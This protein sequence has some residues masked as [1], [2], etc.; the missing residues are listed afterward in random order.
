[1]IAQFRPRKK[2]FALAGAL[3]LAGTLG[4]CA[5]GIE[6]NGKVFDLLGVSANSQRKG[7][8]KLVERAPLVVPPS[9]QLPVPGARSQA[10][11]PRDLAWPVDSDQQKLASVEAKKQKIR[12]LCADRSW[13]E[14]TNQEE[15]DRLTKN[16]TECSSLLGDLIKGATGEEDTSQ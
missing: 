4:G 9:N 5:D 14:R 3:L 11:A 15:F 13:Q 10:A 1:M 8:A 2:L 7:E 12:Q 16:G 6:L